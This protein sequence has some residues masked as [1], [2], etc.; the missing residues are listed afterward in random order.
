LLSG[1]RS[2]FVVM[3]LVFAVQFFAEGLHRTRYAAA[4][5]AIAIL[6]YGFLAAF[7]SSLPL[8]AQRAISFLPIQVDS[9]ARLDGLASIEWRFNMWS[10]VAKDIPKYFWIGKGYA[11][12]PG[13]LLL[14]EESAKR[15]FIQAFDPFIQAGDYH[16]GPLSV[17]I[18]FGIWGVIGFLWFCGASLHALW[19]NMRYG[20]AELRT[21]NTFLFSYFVARFIFFLIFFGAFELDLWLFCSIVG[22]GLSLNGGRKAPPELPRLRF[23]R[24]RTAELEPQLAGI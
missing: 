1:F 15:G 11:I 17:I 19:C 20:D 3:A 16:S 10:V 24:A 13:D 23:K 18:P 21:I 8:A 22:V 9:T 4:A 14:A 6:C 2:V 5:A 7:A 12:D